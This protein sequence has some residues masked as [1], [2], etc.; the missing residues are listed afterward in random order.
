MAV[1]VV[2]SDHAGFDLKESLK[3]FLE[4]LGHQVIDVGCFFKERTDYPL[5]AE[6][7]CQLVLKSLADYAI[8]ICGTGLGMCIASNRFKGIRAALCTNEYMAKMARRHNDA[9]VLC[10]GSRVVGED[11]AKEI[12]RAFLGEKFEGG[13]HERRLYMVESLGEEEITL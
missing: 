13:R 6:R 12:V 9:N 5:F 1:V 3:L 10:L 4:K 8:L 11:L 2:G 7:A